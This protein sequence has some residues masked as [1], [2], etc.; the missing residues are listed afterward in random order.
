MDAFVGEIRAVPFRFA[1]YGWFD[2]D[3]TLYQIRAYQALYSLLGIRYGGDGKTTFAVPD[4][5][6]RIP[7]ANTNPSYFGKQMGSPVVSL[8]TNV[9]PGHSHTAKLLASDNTDYIKPSIKTSAATGKTGQNPGGGYLC[10]T[11]AGNKTYTTPS[12]TGLSLGGTALTISNYTGTIA[13]NGAGTPSN[14]LQPINIT[15]PYVAMRYI[16]AW[17]GIYPVRP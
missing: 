4:L 14:Q 9:L 12:A 11:S 8:D 15:P 2:C 10:S 17:S 16:I 6:G 5:R 7:I 13:L 3:G 1:P